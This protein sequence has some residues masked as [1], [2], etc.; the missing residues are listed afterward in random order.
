MVEPY[1]PY[2]KI[3]RMRIACWM[4]KTKN[5]LSEYAIRNLLSHCNNNYLNASKCYVLRCSSCCTTL[6]LAMVSDPLR[7]F[8]VKW[9]NTADGIKVP[10][11]AITSAWH[12][13]ISL[14]I[15]SNNRFTRTKLNFVLLLQFQCRPGN[16]VG[17]AT[18]YGLDGPGIESRW[19]EVFRTCPERPWGPP[20]LLYN[21]YRVFPGGKVLPGRDAD[22]LPPSSA[23]V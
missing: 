16:V 9:A 5:T 21:G 6:W 23:E 7:F 2:M 1:R 3:W 12:F 15:K 4:P 17:I 19:G 10:A 20:S 18:A 14:R 22:P 13:D 8:F 11:G